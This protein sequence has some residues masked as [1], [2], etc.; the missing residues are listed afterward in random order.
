MY[1]IV[2]KSKICQKQPHN[3]IFDLLIIYTAKIFFDL[4][5]A[6]TLFGCIPKVAQQQ[7]KDGKQHIKQ[8]KRCID[9][10]EYIPYIPY[11]DLHSLHLYSVKRCLDVYPKQV[12]SSP[13]GYGA[14]ESSSK[15]SI[16]MR[17]RALTKKAKSKIQRSL[18]IQIAKIFF[19]FDYGV[20][21]HTSRRDV[22]DVYPKQQGSHKRSFQ[23]QKRCI[24]YSFSLNLRFCLFGESPATQ[25]I[26]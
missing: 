19:D 3:Q 8:Q 20:T 4:S 21:S 16:W 17:S 5:V 1:G 23:Q 15:S 2:D 6:K 13:I 12:S 10:T 7:P 9:D 11:T 14:G 24:D 18:I 26:H 25:G 22:R